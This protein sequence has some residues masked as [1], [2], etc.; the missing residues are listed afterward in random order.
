MAY[1]DAIMTQVVEMMN[2]AAQSINLVG[3]G[4][5]LW[6]IL[7]LCLLVVL[8]IQKGSTEFLIVGI[9]RY[10]VAFRHYSD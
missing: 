8:V 2:N 9:E 4:I 3:G 10:M 6:I 7:W 1:V 5:K